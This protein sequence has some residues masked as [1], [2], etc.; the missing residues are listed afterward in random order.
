MAAVSPTRQR[1]LSAALEVFSRKGYEAASMG[2]IAG[3]LGIKAPS[4][5]KY[6]KGKEE[7]YEALTPMLDEHYTALWASAAARHTQLEREIPTP[8]LLG[9]EQLER[10]TLSWLR[11]ELD[12]PQARCFRRLMTLSQ[13]DATPAQ[14][15]WLWAEPLE[16]Y[17]GFFDRLIARDILR[18]GDP[19]VMAVEYLAPIFQY[20]AMM[21]RAPGRQEQYLEGVTRH[22]RQFH[23]VFAHREQRAP[24]NQSPVSRLFRR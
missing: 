5:Y 19:H 21:D 18:R 11:A 17:E 20:L 9:A 14:D 6:F 4:L 15:R 13:F 8:G 10:E 3:A 12:D 16:L 22:I 23:R 2:D 1:A 7:L 24:A